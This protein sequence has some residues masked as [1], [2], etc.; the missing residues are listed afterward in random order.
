MQQAGEA[1]RLDA[2]SRPRILRPQQSAFLQFGPSTEDAPT[3]QEGDVDVPE[4]GEPEGAAPWLR[5]QLQVGLLL[6]G[7]AGPV[8]LYL[9]ASPDYL[10]LVQCR[11]DLWPPALFPPEHPEAPVRNPCIWA[12]AGAGD[13]SLA[14]TVGMQAGVSSLGAQAPWRARAH[15]RLIP[16]CWR[17]S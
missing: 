6:P 3:L 1:C 12:G 9:C 5:C 8:P 7:A 11:P 16:R 2:T 10:Y 14:A 17:R 13:G 4:V 15:P